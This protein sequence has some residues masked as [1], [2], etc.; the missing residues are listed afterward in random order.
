MRAVWGV[1][2]LVAALALAG[3][4]ATPAAAQED[5]RGALAVEV[6]ELLDAEA[7]VAEMF[8]NMA[9]MMAASMGPELQLSQADQAR[10]SVILNEE[11]RAAAPEFSRRLAGVYAEHM[12]EMQ[13]RETIAFLRSPSGAALIST[14]NTAQRQLEAIGQE[15][16]VR[17]ALQS[18]MR[19]HQERAEQ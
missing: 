1:Q 3:A 14:Q 13:L 9:P 17:V 6:V 15:I 7:T 10:L 19:L 2:S 5:P 8:D 18:L 12:T 4:A 16:G 11:L